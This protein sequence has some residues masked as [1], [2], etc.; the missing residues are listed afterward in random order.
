MT[1]FLRKAPSATL[2][3]AAALV[4]ACS[5][6]TITGPDSQFRDLPSESAA[7][8]PQAEG[9]ASVRWNAIARDLVAARRIDPPMAARF[10][11]MLGVAQ[12]SAI[13]S[14]L[15]AEHLSSKAREAVG[16]A[17]VVAASASVL[18]VEFP[19]DLALI[20][21][22]EAF[23]VS[24]LFANGAHSRS[25][26]DA[27]AVGRAAAQRVL[28]RAAR[29][30]FDRTWTGTVPTGAGLWFTR[31][32]NASPLRPA[33]GKVRPWL[34]RSGD[35][36]RPPPPPTFA[37][38]AFA[39]ALHEVRAISDNRTP[40]QL[41]IAIFWA[42]GAGT[43]TPPG[44]WN[45]I[46]AD[47]IAKRHLDEERAALTFA[48]LNMSLM[49]AGIACWDAKYTYWL[50]RPSQADPL[51]TTPVGLP[52]FPS[53]VSGHA[54]FS[55]AAS[56]VLGALFPADR[57]ALDAMA[58]EAALS[59]MYGGIHYR[60]D[61]ER[62]LELGRRIGTIAAAMIPTGGGKERSLPIP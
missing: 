8:A 34:L 46:A 60:F 39:A 31:V 29:D 14:A 58:N 18:A 37:S 27:V 13:T 32:D 35:Q 17:A 49:D 20:R 40:G 48:L 5:D 62:G 45:A 56:T 47:L 24:D 7:R 21:A 6:R 9:T 19:D 50:I 28:D 41:A 38:P 53:Y 30:G 42:D 55:G 52:Y 59:R 61:N 26:T 51:I 44:H 36:F 22:S 10:Y 25:L 54:T 16:R 43:S 1:N 3:A 57:R 33:W 4:A 11:A 12:Y 23:D 2:V 15:R